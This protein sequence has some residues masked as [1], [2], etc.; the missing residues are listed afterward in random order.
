MH[1]ILLPTAGSHIVDRWATTRNGVERSP[2]KMTA[3]TTLFP[4][5]TQHDLKGEAFKGKTE[6][7]NKVL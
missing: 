7:E 1:S 3:T 2:Q 6:K 4:R 5:G